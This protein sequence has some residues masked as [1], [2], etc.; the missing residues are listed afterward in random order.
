[1]DHV[2]DIEGIDRQ[3]VTIR[4][5]VPVDTDIEALAV[6]QRD[7]ASLGQLYTELEFHSLLQKLEV[8][9][10]TPKATAAPFVIVDRIQDVGPAVEAVRAADVVSVTTTATA[11]E[12]MCAT[13]VG[14]SLATEES[15]CNVRAL[16]L[17][18]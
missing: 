12:A 8:T 13:L 9:T 18:G 7:D 16:G 6:E 11:S 4:R 5:D 1:M 10:S 3:L 2:V 15:S 14:I 17:P